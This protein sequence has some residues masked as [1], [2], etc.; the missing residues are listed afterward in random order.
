M[1]KCVL[2]PGHNI[3]SQGAENDSAG[4]T[5]YFF[6]S[7]LASRIKALVKD[8][9][10]STV[11][12][13]T[14][15]ELPQQVNVEKPDF[16]ISLHCNASDT[17]TSGTEILC[18]KDSIEGNRIS[19]IVR[20]KIIHAL[21]LRD[22]GIKEITE[23]ERGGYFLKNT[24]APAIIVEPFFIDNDSDYQHAENSFEELA[25]AYAASI[26]EIGKSLTH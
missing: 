18:Y 24:N 4:T 17:K 14:H 19:E 22:R 5:E 15:R 23:D 21:N 12:E 9:E 8:V 25:Q 2:V 10:I 7:K 16:V 20:R 13:R 3:D 6:N 26:E 1:I 11:Y